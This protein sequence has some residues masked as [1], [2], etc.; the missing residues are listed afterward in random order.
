[1]SSD[2][3]CPLCRLRRPEPTC[4]EHGIPTIAAALLDSPE[5]E[6]HPGTELGGR[7][8]I[9]GLIGS[10]GMGQVY[11]A[12]Q[13]S[14]QRKVALKTLHPRLLKDAD[15]LSRF[16]REAR[17]A[18]L[19]EG[20]GIVRIYDFGVDEATSRPYIVMELVRGA[21]LRARIAEAKGLPPAEAASVCAQ[22]CHALA[23][24]KDAGIVHRDLKPDNILLAGGRG[25]A[26]VVKVMDFGVAKLDRAQHGETGSLTGSGA[27]IGTPRTMAPEQILGQSVDFR[28]DLYALGCVLHEMLTAEPVFAGDDPIV[29]INQHLTSAPPPLPEGR[30]IPP[31][32]VELR[33]C[34]LE[35]E[36]DRRPRDL[37]LLARRFEAIASGAKPAPPDASDTVSDV[38]R[39]ET[40]GSSTTGPQRSRR[41]AWIVAGVATVVLV[42]GAAAMLLLRESGSPPPRE[43]APALEAV[44]TRPLPLP[45]LTPKSRAAAAETR[46][47]ERE[48]PAPAPRVVEIR[49]S[50]T[51]RVL[52]DGKDLGET[53]LPIRVSDGEAPFVVV[54]R[55]EGFEPH[56]LRLLPTSPE[57]L[58]VSLSPSPAATV[59]RSVAPAPGSRHG[60]KQTKTT[61]PGPTGKKPPDPI[62]TEGW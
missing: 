15:Q 10:G 36:R 40:W 23:E 39:G 34:L 20:P 42:A 57:H 8:R 38:F 18:S 60:E 4:P 48:P 47:D 30:G 25:A 53:P 49:C 58:D 51:A 35:K 29:I 24:A 6:L 3:Y 61:E 54:L 1:M 28:A 32:L 5:P 46:R 17:A 11:S 59:E 16:Y 14:I 31:E 44:P 55:R 21:T 37:L 26:P 13:L 50:P 43:T 62:D 45:A 9:D 7:Y 52:R 22:V 56:E 41:G 19:L 12:T 27:V 33:D 2:R